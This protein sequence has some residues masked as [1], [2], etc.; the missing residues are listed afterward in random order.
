MTEEP[1]SN[2]KRKYFE[3]FGDLEKEISFLRTLTLAFT[4]L[5]LAAVFFLFLA[6]KKTPVVIRV[7][8]VAGAEV[9][10]D[11]QSINEATPYEMIGFAKRFTARYTGHNSY[12]VSRDLTE[13][14]N[15]MTRRFQK[16]AQKNLIDSGILTKL[17]QAGI[18]TQIDFKEAKVERNS[19]DAGIVSLVG[20]R[21]VT[22]YEDP[23][24]NQDFL[25]R[26]EIVLKKVSRSEKVPEGL[27]IEEYRE[28][29][30]NELSE[31]RSS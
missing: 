17:V 20:V 18:D 6:A 11:L 3:V 22:K 30:I 4:G 7:T 27:L 12:T 31:R 5:L 29:L 9:I 24:F 15:Y 25:F 23:G 2:I 26:A 13:S 16:S 1:F 10:K 14:F 28:I 21:R 8:E 19:Q